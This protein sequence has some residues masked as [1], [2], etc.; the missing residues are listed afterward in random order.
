MKPSE[1]DQKIERIISQMAQ[2]DKPAP[3]FEQ[4]RRDHPQAV[5]KLISG[6]QSAKA[7]WPP[8]PQN[9]WANIRPINLAKIAAAV[10]LILA[11]GFVIGRSSSTDPDMDQL[12]QQLEMSLV[13]SLEPKLQQSISQ[14]LHNEILSPLAAR[15]VQFEDEI[16][17]QMQGIFSDFAAE[18]QIAANDNLNQLLSELMQAFDLAQMRERNL[19]MEALHQL[20]QRRWADHEMLQNDLI[21]VAAL[22]HDE[23]SRNRQ[24]LQLLL[25]GGDKIIK[26]DYEEIQQKP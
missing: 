23:I 15:Q 13:H 14:K 6:D 17:R 7:P 8:Q 5:K 10:L 12:Q 16:Q 2:G 22:A 25:T 21:E 11:A 9:I 18:F 4:W 19:F 26:Q 24:E 3:D 20:D 1:K